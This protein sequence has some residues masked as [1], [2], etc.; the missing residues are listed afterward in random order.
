M[1]QRRF[2]IVFFVV[3][4]LGFRLSFADADGERSAVQKPSADTGLV[5]VIAVDQLR[6]DRLDERLPG[7]LGALI[8]QGR[9]FTQATLGHG[10]STTCPGHA[11]MLTG[12]HPNRHGLPSNTFFDRAEGTV[13]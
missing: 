2:Q 11:V 9:W 10:V 6:R 8:R 7:G 3:L 4:S 1:V 13:R 5:V 12:L